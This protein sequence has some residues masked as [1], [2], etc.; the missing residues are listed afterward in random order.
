[1]F[2]RFSVSTEPEIYENAKRQIREKGKSAA[3][4]KQLFHLLYCCARKFFHNRTMKNLLLVSLVLIGI[5]VICSATTCPPDCNGHGT[6]LPSGS[7]QCTDPW[8]GSDCQYN[9]DTKLTGTCQSTGDPHYVNFGAN[10]YSYQGNVLR[11]RRVC[12][13]L[14]DSGKRIY[15]LVYTTENF[16]VQ[17]WHTPY[18]L[19]ANAEVNRA[20][21]IQCEYPSFAEGSFANRSIHVIVNGR[22]F[23]LNTDSK[24]QQISSRSELPITSYVICIHSFI[25]NEYCR[26]GSGTYILALTSLFGTEWRTAEFKLRKSVAWTKQEAD[27]VNI[28]IKLDS[29]WTNKVFGLCDSFLGTPDTTILPR[30]ATTPI[31]GTQANVDKTFG[32]S[33]RVRCNEVGFNNYSLTECGDAP[34]PTPV[35]RTF[36][37]SI[38]LHFSCFCLDVF[39]V[40]FTVFKHL[41]VAFLIFFLSASCTVVNE[42]VADVCAL[43]CPYRQQCEFDVKQSCNLAAAQ[44]QIAAFESLRTAQKWDQCGGTWCDPCNGHGTCS[45]GKCT[46]NAGWTGAQCQT[47][48]QAPVCTP[49]C[50]NGYCGLDGKCKCYAGWQGATCNAAEPAKPCPNNCSG[51][52]TCS[53]GVCKCNPQYY[54]EKCET[55]VPCSKSVATCSAQGDPHYDTFDNFMYSYQGAGVFYQVYSS[56]LLVQAWVCY[57]S[58]PLFLFL[59]IVDQHA[60]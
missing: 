3:A 57:S 51:R 7:C 50:V 33:W 48:T 25:S 6:R 15:W 18:G 24:A 21:Y 2:Q 17:E 60:V 31:A 13:H 56:E 46:C 32:P 39:S 1:M 38:L 28:Y 20:V 9:H 11:K 27:L 37:S 26:S 42:K 36:F 16:H 34:T 4:G 30:G 53:N 49:A 19:N 41:L 45:N 52:G 29:K 47:M 40:L 35:P 14:R 12:T 10:K 22:S 5:A 44:T 23:Y 54:G 58:F 8:Y 43:A 59:F 55:L